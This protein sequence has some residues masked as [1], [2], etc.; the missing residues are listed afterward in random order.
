MDQNVRYYW[1]QELANHLHPSHI[2]CA[3]NP[4]IYNQNLHT[5]IQRIQVGNGQ[6]IS[7]LF[8]MPIIIDIHCNRF[9]IYTLVSEIN[10]NLD[11]VIG[12]KIYLNE[13]AL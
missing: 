12:I 4:Y 8:I 2:I 1:I 11:L 9:E 13:K 10:E 6:F 5:K 7:V 3:A